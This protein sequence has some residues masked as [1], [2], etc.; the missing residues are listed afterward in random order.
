MSTFGEKRKRSSFRIPIV[1]I[2]NSSTVTG[3][4]NGGTMDG[5]KNR[6]MMMHST[7]VRHGAA[8]EQL[9]LGQETSAAMDESTGTSSIRTR[10]CE[11][12]KRINYQHTRHINNISNINNKPLQP[13]MHVGSRLSVPA[14]PSLITNK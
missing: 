3:T 7:L 6:K 2:Q 10:L 8:I 9:L 14:Y 4:T 13:M 11:K 5:S 12:D 1:I